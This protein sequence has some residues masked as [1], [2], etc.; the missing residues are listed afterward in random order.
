MSAALRFFFLLPRRCRNL[1]KHKKAGILRLCVQ[2][3]GWYGF[4]Y[5]N[6]TLL[7]S[8]PKL[9]ADY[10]LL[11]VIEHLRLYLLSR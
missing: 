7:C 6:T 5:S 10:L 8:I 3:R 11:Y 1:V 4:P 9:E 2:K